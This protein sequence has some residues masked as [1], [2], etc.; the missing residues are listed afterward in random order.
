M[1]S[2]LAILEDDY[3]IDLAGWTR[4]SA[5]A[6]SDDG[7]V[8]VGQGY[9]PD[10][11]LEAW[12]VELAPTGFVVTEATDSEDVDVGDG[13]CDTDLTEPGD[14]CTL[15][16]A[17]QEAV[18]IPDGEPTPRISFNISGDAPPQILLAS[19]LPPLTREAH[20]D[21]SSQPGDPVVLDG[22]LLGSEA[23]GLV[24]EADGASVRGLTIV[25][26]SGYGLDVV[27][28][29]R[30]RLV[31][32]HIGVSESGDALPNML[33]AIRITGAEAD[34]T[35]GGA[36]DEDRNTLLGALDVLDEARARVRI[37]T[38]EVPEEQAEGLEL[39][40]L[41]DL[42]GDGP[43]CGT[44]AVADGSTRTPP[45]VLELS[46]T[47]VRGLT[48]PG[49]T[50]VVYRVTDLGADNGRYW[51]RR[52]EGLTLGIAD[53]TGAFDIAVE[54]AEG[55]RI[56]LSAVGPDGRTSELSQARRPVVFAPGIG[57]TWLRDAQGT[58]LWI[59]LALGTD[60]KN[61][62]MR[63]L[64][65]A[66]DG[67]TSVESLVAQ[68]VLESIGPLS[69]I[70]GPIHEHL[71]AEGYPGHPFNQDAAM[72]D[73][74]RF[75][76]DWRRSATVLA[77]DL[78]ALIDR[79]TT[80]SGETDASAARSCQ[81]DLVAHSNG[82][83]ISSVYIQRDAEHARDHLHRV[84]TSGTPYLG[85]DQAYAAHT[86]GYIFGAEE[87]LSYAGGWN[88]AWGDMLAMTRN[89]PGAYG[90]LPSEAYFEAM[91]PSSSS[92]SHGYGLVDLYNDPLDGYDATLQFLTNTKTQGGVLPLG[93]ERNAQIRSDQASSVLDV[94]GDWRSYEG[95]PHVYRHVGQLVGQT[96]V[97]WFMGPGPALVPAG[98]TTRSEAGDTDRHRAYRERLVP[99]MGFGD[100]TVPLLSASLGRNPLVGDTDF[101]GVDESPWIEEFE[102]YA[103][104][105]GK[106]V[107][108]DCR[109][110]AAQPSDPDALD[111]ITQTLAS[112][113]VV[114]AAV[115]SSRTEIASPV[116]V[117]T[118]GEVIY[119]LAT[120]PITV[121][122]T[123]AAGRQTGPPDVDVPGDIAF[124]VP[125]VSY[126]ATRFG[127]TLGLRPDSAYTLTVRPAEPDA[128]VTLVRLTHGQD[129]VTQILYPDQP[130]P[131]GG[132]LAFEL[133]DTGT[134]LDAAWTRDADG[135]GAPESTVAP[136]AILEG[137]GASL[138]LPMA[139]PNA[140]NLPAA[141][142][143]DVQTATLRI[144][145]TG[146]DGWTFT[147]DEAAPWLSMS[148]VS[149]TVPEEVFLTMDPS[150][151]PNGDAQED[152]FLTVT[153]GDYSRQTRI[154]VTLR[155]GV[156]VANEDAPVAPHALALHA[157]VPNPS[158]G[159]IALAFDL[160]EARTVRLSVHDALGRE[161]AV[162]AEGARPLGTHEARLDADA[163]APGVYVVRLVAGADVR[164][165]R[166][167]VVR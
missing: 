101:S 34:V 15:R 63:R 119:A 24:V 48:A 163:L 81:V 124:E 87:V 11:K 31:G 131:E 45:R 156:F 14:Q 40:S 86:N 146:T 155:V 147:L 140:V 30:V 44:W 95:P 6:I 144:P 22:A 70:Y 161:V 153:N 27:D 74:W 17:I 38:L 117:A 41:L 150:G 28:A 127:A 133:A 2:L 141:D 21:A 110:V 125:G 25:G 148:S 62:R 7:Q 134:A 53:A 32:N 47:R 132:T 93:M 118:A 50:V 152:I 18:L 129:A 145:A 102:R 92:Y 66:P 108:E 159:T 165:Q 90:L 135:D 67:Q 16:A 106:L 68:E 57:G 46:T 64:A 20:I 82:G 94:I 78:R 39:R 107:K 167:T 35:V 115:A 29:A 136:A 33:G 52:A 49:D 166:L 69:D 51:A 19:P 99:I 154:P 96:E 12:R 60:A 36:T 103:C 157:P 120:A 89:V 100:K 42:G 76:N 160:V 4:L 137:G 98:T 3:G 143:L 139:Q 138:A 122:L 84:L 149:G 112:G 8:I 79:I 123:D 158:R 114:P 71:E 116:D 61:A 88:V 91:D 54:L 5:N 164:T 128:V 1:Q 77:N 142:G 80:N 10:G 65:M 23:S 26:F 121:T 105:H 83:V 13:Q 59:P 58:D 97:G 43:T 130:L 37:N 75:P 111:R 73:Q 104:E 126:H 56:A 55:D 9:N 151:L 113:S 109:P 85:A 162:P 72:L